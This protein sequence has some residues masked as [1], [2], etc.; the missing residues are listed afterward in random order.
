MAAVDAWQRTQKTGEFH[1]LT[2][3]PLH[4]SQAQR[5]LRSLRS[6]CSICSSAVSAATQAI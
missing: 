5:K 2:E 4:F 1:A 6:Q 3:A